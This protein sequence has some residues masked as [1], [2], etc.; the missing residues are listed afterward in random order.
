MKEELRVCVVVHHKINPTETFI[1]DQVRFLGAKTYVLSPKILK[2]FF[3]KRDHFKTFLKKNKI[4]VVLAQFGEVG[5]KITKA[6]EEARV[7]LVTHFHGFDVYEGDKQKLS[8]RY[9]DLF[10]RNV[11]LIAVSH[12][13]EERLISLGARKDN[14]SVNPCSVNIEI[15]KPKVLEKKGKIFVSVGRFVEKKSP[16]VTIRAFIKA[17][18]K[19]QDDSLELHMYGRG[20]LLKECQVFV[21]KNMIQNIRFFGEVTHK[22]IPGVLQDAYALLH[23]S[24][25]ANNGDSEGT[26]V[27]ILEASASG[28]PVIATQHGGIPEAVINT[29]TGLLCEEGD[30]QTMTS[31]IVSLA[32]DK[33]RA[34]VLG[35]A[36]RKHIENNYSQKM[37][38]TKLK[39]ILYESSLRNQ[40]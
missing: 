25:T 30:V 8:E 4:D 1:L 38:G 29:Q 5:V 6:C 27:V 10:E 36:G 21:K 35:L 3:R 28:I 33:E 7:S 22:E 9:K 18:L 15:F 19:I 32:E 31:H 26:P 16:M 17:Y 34:S 20:P 23:H 14:I 39:N 40:K 24:V 12:H 2:R 37:R 11:T 13:M